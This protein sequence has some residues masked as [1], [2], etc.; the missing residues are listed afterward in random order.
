M[1]QHQVEE[2][3]V[4]LHESVSSTFASSPLTPVCRA[5]LRLA[6]DGPSELAFEYVSHSTL[7]VA[8][9]SFKVG[10]LK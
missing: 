9:V 7:S 2:D 6:K 3:E 5:C 1:D 10:F 8:P 4:R